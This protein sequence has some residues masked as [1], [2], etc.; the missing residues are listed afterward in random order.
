[1][2]KVILLFSL[3]FAVAVT[4]FLAKHNDSKVYHYYSTVAD[5]RHFPL[6]ISLVGSIHKVDFDALD[7]IAVFDVG[8]TDKQ[9]QILENIEKVKVYQVEKTNPDILTYFKT[10][11]AGREVRG[12]F[13]WKPVVFKQ[14]LDLYPYFVYLDSGSLVLNSPDNLFKHIKQNGYFIVEISPHSIQERITKPVMDKLVAKLPEHQQAM[15]MSKETP[16]I[17]AGFQ[18][19]SREVY[20]NYVKPMYELSADLTLFEDDGSSPLGFGAGRHDQ[21]LFSIFANLEKFKLN[22]Q[23]WSILNVDGEEVPFHM[24][25]DRPE[26]NSQTVIYRSRKDMQYGGNKLPHIHW[27]NRTSK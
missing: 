13:S 22:N 4:Y 12:W 25:W 11:S 20:S 21:T 17:D 18:G 14:S 6:L 24:H 10:N 26:V 23:G 19:I 2:K 1:M 9:K 5:E 27:R 8:L 7:E 16:M 15:I 3:V